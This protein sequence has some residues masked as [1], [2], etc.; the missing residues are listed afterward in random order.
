MA[1]IRLAMVAA[2]LGGCSVRIGAFAAAATTAVTEASEPVGHRAGRVC[3]WWVLGA[4]LGLPSIDG[5]M[6][7]AMTPV[8]GRLMRHVTLTSDHSFYVV[9]G[10]NCYTVQGEVFR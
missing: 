4:P 6:A 8:G 5:A 2:F 7:A 1:A 10:Q 9:V 3:R